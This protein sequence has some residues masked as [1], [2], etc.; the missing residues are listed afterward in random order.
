MGDIMFTKKGVPHSFSRGGITMDGAG[1]VRAYN[2]LIRGNQYVLIVYS[3]EIDKPVFFIA[4]QTSCYKYSR[5]L[6][7]TMSE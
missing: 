5:A 1:N 7:K 3:L 6:S 2:Y 4:H